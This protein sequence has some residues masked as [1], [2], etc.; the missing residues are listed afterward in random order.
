VEKKVFVAKAVRAAFWGALLFLMVMALA[1]FDVGGGVLK[2][3]M[4]HMLGFY[5]LT[6]LGLASWGRRSAVR[7]TL[8]LATLGAAIELLQATPLVGRDGDF[9]DW[10]A[11]VAGIAIALVPAIFVGKAKDV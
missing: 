2:D 6:V 9:Q 3:K 5:T 8:G 7:L 4:Q 1:P 10:A 11:D